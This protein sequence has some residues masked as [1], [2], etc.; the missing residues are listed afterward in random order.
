[1]AFVDRVVQ[2]PNRYIFT[3]ENGNDTGPYTLVRDEGT[4]TEAGTLLN[5][6]NLTD[7]ITALVG[8]SMLAE[9]VVLADDFSVTHG[10]YNNSSG[11]VTKAGYTPIG[12]VGMRT[13]NATNGGTYNTWVCLHSFYLIG[14]TVYFT[15][16]NVHTSTDAKIKVTATVL[17]VKS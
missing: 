12:I 1:M 7:E 5:A 9:S 4:V 8:A 15:V 3:D 13:Q 2:Y 14:T 11:S 16:R 10:S 17:Y 6:Q